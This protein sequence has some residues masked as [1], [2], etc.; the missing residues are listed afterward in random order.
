M[1][2]TTVVARAS[3]ERRV[4]NSGRPA[5]E[6]AARSQLTRESSWTTVIEP[7][8]W[9][10]AAPAHDRCSRLPPG[11]Q[12]TGRLSGVSALRRP[13]S[14]LCP[15]LCT[16]VPASEQ[17]LSVGAVTSEGSNGAVPRN[18]PAPPRERERERE[19]EEEREERKKGNAKRWRRDG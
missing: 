10:I 14:D 3:E 1:D 5:G 8:E 7:K 17:P 12:L 4:G 9:R 2:R 13:P 6:D 11:S 15:P 18:D 16:R 19:E